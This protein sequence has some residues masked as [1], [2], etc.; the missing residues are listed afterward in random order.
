MKKKHVI[1]IRKYGNGSEVIWGCFWA[2]DL[3]SLATL[4]GNIGQDRYIDCLAEHFLPWY[5]GMSKEEK[6]EFLFPEDGD[7]CH[8]DVY[9]TLY[10]K[11][12]YLVDRF[13]FWPTQSPD[14]K[15]N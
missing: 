7:P 6:G 12:R 2:G 1:G 11:G 3:G 10:K 5:E 8:T 15:T 4:K 14:P 13:T 9:A